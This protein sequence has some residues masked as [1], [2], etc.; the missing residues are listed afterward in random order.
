MISKLVTLRALHWL[1]N[2]RSAR[3][4]NVTNA[5][6][7]LVNERREVLSLVTPEIGPGPF[8]ITLANGFRVEPGDEQRVT[9]LSPT[10]LALGRTI[11]DVADAAVWQPSPEWSRLRDRTFTDRS[12]TILLPD[13]I[14][15]GLEQLLAG[16]LVGDEPGI[17]AGIAAL[18]GRGEGLT[19]AGDDVLVGVLHALWVWRPHSTWGQRI[20]A[21]A[22]P[23]TTTLSANFLHA[24]ADGEAAWQWHTLV[25][26]DADA[27]NRIVSVGHLSG[28][29]AW[30]GFTRAQTALAQTDAATC[31]PLSDFRAS[32]AP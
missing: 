26:G 22:A 9:V 3:V 24:A 14:E 15:C 29:Y 32:V 13:I 5:A 2:T 28:V 6:C 31:H 12:Q 19:P 10:A 11:I 21:I 4:L 1:R 30:A 8:T 27:V 23:R 16:I 25:D 20:A 7:N 18:A 17:L